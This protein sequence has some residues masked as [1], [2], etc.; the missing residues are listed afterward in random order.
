VFPRPQEGWPRIHS[1]LLRFY[2]QRGK[3][4]IQM[5]MDWHGGLGF[6]EAELRNLTV[7]VCDDT[8]IFL[9]LNAA[10]TVDE[11]TAGF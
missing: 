9:R 2:K 8:F 7:D 11:A 4:A 10:G 6:Y 3:S 1:E 5:V